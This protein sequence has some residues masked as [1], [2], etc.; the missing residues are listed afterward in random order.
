MY[1]LLSGE[2][3]FNGGDDNEILEAVK[4]GKYSFGSSKWKGI[5]KEAKALIKLML[6]FEPEFRITAA[7]ALKNE[8]FA[9]MSKHN[10]NKDSKNLINALGDL[11]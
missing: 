2:P 8:W 1:I 9:I 5:S 11:Q 6:T 7:D 4:S 3:P 10:S